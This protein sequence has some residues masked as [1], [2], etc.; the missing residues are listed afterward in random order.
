MVFYFD[1]PFFFL[2]EAKKSV[3]MG[4]LVVVDDHFQLL[5]CASYSLIEAQDRRQ[6]ALDLVICVR[7]CNFRKTKRCIFMY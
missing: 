3:M 2:Q 1:D 7:E 6:L 5:M 4:V